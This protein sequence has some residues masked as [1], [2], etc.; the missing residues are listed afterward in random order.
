MLSEV[1]SVRIK[2]FNFLLLLPFESKF[3]CKL[4]RLW[5]AYFPG[6]ISSCIGKFVLSFQYFL[7]FLLVF[8]INGWLGNMF[9]SGCTAFG[10]FHMFIAVAI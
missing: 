5:L 2:H 6:Y 4:V 10:A 8:F 9:F 1:N 3:S 7:I